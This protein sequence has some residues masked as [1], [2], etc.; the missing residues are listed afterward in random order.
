[1]TQIRNDS[2]FR[3][4]PDAAFRVVDG[5]ALIVMPKEA[6]MVTLNAVGTRVWELLEG[7]TAAEIAA[8]LI[9]EFDVSEEEATADTISFLEILFMKEMAIDIEC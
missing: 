7:R 9:L 5:Q 6:K 3:R 4:N 8:T 1:M 2:T